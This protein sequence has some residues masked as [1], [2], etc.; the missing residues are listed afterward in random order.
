VRALLDAGADKDR[1][2]KRY[3]MIPLY[4]AAQTGKWQCAQVLLGSGPSPDQ[5]HIEISLASQH[6]A[7]I[8]AGVPVF[9]T[10][11]STGRSGFSTR[12][13]DF[14]ITDKQRSHRS[15]IYHV[16]MPFFMR[17]SCLDFGMHEGVV[18]NYPASHGCIR[19]PGD[20][21]RKLFAEIPVG[22]VVTVK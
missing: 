14:V 5:L 21:A 15:T 18:P 7:L 2:T 19:L 10:V 6:V 4:I 20:A 22:T 12:T 13:G 1:A 3:K 8:K 11:C 17:L 9:S 16:D